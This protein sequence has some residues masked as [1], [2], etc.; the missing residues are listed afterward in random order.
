MRVAVTGTHGL[1]ARHLLPALESRGHVVVKL[2]RSGTGAT[3]PG[4]VTWDPTASEI[5]ATQLADVDAFVH[6]AGVGIGDRRWNDA[7]RHAVMASRV[8]GTALLARTAA[9]LDPRPSVFVSASAVGYYG[10]RGDEELDEL[11]P[12]GTG[13]LAE[14]CRRWEAATAATAAA[15]IRTVLA[16]SGVIQA[17]DGGA[18]KTQLPLFKLGLGSRLGGGHQWVSWIGIDDEVGGIIH[19]LE[20]EEV[21]GPM[22]LVAPAPVTNADYTRT[23]G[24]VLRRPAFWVAPAAALKLVLGAEMAS[25]MLLASQR[26]SPGVLARTG[27]EWQDTRLEPALRAV[28]DR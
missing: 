23:L 27:Y 6:L 15:G 12:S 16:R 18:L 24:R 22:N 11:S 10:D 26:V 28:L 19:A 17:G 14:V 7:H 21:D 8:Q 5:E 13:Y 25:E 2:V 20:H 3:Q 4:E 1:V 9:G